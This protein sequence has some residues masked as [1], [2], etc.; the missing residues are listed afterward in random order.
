MFS[1][2]WSSV[3]S[4]AFGVQWCI[5]HSNPTGWTGSHAR[6][7]PARGIRSSWNAT[8]V[9]AFASDVQDASL[10]EGAQVNRGDKFL[11]LGHIQSVH[12]VPCRGAERG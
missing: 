1:S 11:R 4:G 12:P 9:S 3:A 5:T 8:V 10:L 7:E 6:M 2:L